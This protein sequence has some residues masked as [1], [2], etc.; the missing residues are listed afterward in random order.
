MIKTNYFSI[1]E[2]ILIVEFNKI[3]HRERNSTIK[4]KIVKRQ[5]LALLNSRYIKVYDV[6]HIVIK[7]R[8]SKSYFEFDK[9][10][11]IVNKCFRK[12]MKNISTIF[13]F[14]TINNKEFFMIKAWYYSYFKFVIDIIFI[15]FFLFEFK[16]KIF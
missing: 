6:K 13:K 12:K 14:Q 1:V 3:A 16:K 10:N 11:S 2:L 8:C 7:I 9:Y 15:R 4:C 5:F